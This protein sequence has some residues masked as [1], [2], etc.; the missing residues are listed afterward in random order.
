MREFIVHEQRLI[1]QYNLYS[2]FSLLIYRRKFIRIAN[3][4]FIINI[5]CTQ[6]FVTLRKNVRTFCKK[7][8]FF[9]FSVGGRRDVS[10]HARFRREKK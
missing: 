7:F 10:W 8:T 5:L 2:Y 3:Q 4:K 1:E 6:T 9:L